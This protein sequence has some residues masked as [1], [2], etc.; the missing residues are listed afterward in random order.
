MLP[1]LIQRISRCVPSLERCF[2]H[3][4][5]L[6]AAGLLSLLVAAFL[7]SAAQP[8]VLDVNYR[9]NDGERTWATLPLS[10]TS[11]EGGTIAVDIVFKMGLLTP[12]SLR[13]IPDDCIEDIALNA[14]PIVLPEGDVCDFERGIAI[15]L[16]SALKPGENLVSITLS[17]FGGVGGIDMTLPAFAAVSLVP[18]ALAIIG[19]L[20]LAL[21]IFPRLRFL[22]DDPLLLG[23]LIAGTALRTIYLLLTPANVRGHD[24]DGHIEYILYMTSHVFPPPSDMGWETYQPPL[25]YGLSALWLH[26]TRLLPSSMLSDRSSLQLFSLL[27]SVATLTG[28]AWIAKKTLGSFGRTF[29][30]LALGLLA[31]LPSWVFF[32]ARI[33]NDVLSLFVLV[34]GVAAAIAWWE[35]G[36]TVRWYLCCVI[37]AL[38]VWVKANGIALLPPILLLY[39]LRRGEGTALHRVER[40]CGGLVLASVLILSMYAPRMLSHSEGPR[41]VGNALHIGDEMRL[42]NA[43]ENLTTFDP[44]RFL[45]EPFNSPWEGHRRE[46]FLE[47]VYR[48]AF[49]GE[50]NFGDALIPFG[51]AILGVSL[52]ALALAVVGGGMGMVRHAKQ[53]TP[54]MLVG[55]AVFFAH[56]CFRL[57]YPFSV[58]Q[59]FRYSPLLALPV[60]IAAAAGASMGGSA[61][62]RA[63]TWLLVLLC[64]LCT[65][66]TLI[67]APGSA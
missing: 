20:L 31:A 67:I 51:S 37:A 9:F 6:C 27:L 35:R 48:S 61:L 60:A 22:R 45:L 41:L 42:P 11:D 25:Y 53:F 33:N 40:A 24:V 2:A 3:R 49:F 55:L 47:Y 38:A 23:T 14:A 26:I 52:F 64:V 15:D 54:V 36:G 19:M 12:T 57:S 66:F 13:F 16:S 65:T 56:L 58:S 17:D 29:P 1:S 44:A 30:A 21:G 4:R 8:K 32:S 10:F 39:V 46:F 50:F 18:Q 59:D 63:S 34:C 28:C 43:L 62:R 5:A 7:Q